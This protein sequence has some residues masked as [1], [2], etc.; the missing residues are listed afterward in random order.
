MDE[1]KDKQHEEV[2]D[3]DIEQFIERNINFLQHPLSKQRVKKKQIS[4]EI[5]FVT[6]VYRCVRTFATYGENHRLAHSHLS[7]FFHFFETYFATFDKFKLEHVR[8]EFLLFNRQVLKENDYCTYFIKMLVDNNILSIEIYK[9]CSFEELIFFI[10]ILKSRSG[11]LAEGKDADL[12]H[13]LKNIK[14]EEMPHICLDESEYLEMMT[15]FPDEEESIE[16]QKDDFGSMTFEGMSLSGGLDISGM[17]M[18]G[19]EGVVAEKE[20]S[21]VR[22]DEYLETEASSKTLKEIQQKQKHKIPK[23]QENFALTDKNVLPE[24]QKISQEKIRSHEQQQLPKALKFEKMLS[25]DAGRPGPVERLIAQS[26]NTMRYI[27]HFIGLQFIVIA[28][29]VDIVVDTVASYVNGIYQNWRWMRSI[30]KAAKNR[31]L[32]AKILM[33]THDVNVGRIYLSRF[34]CFAGHSMQIYKKQNLGKYASYV[35]A[36]FPLKIALEMREHFDGM[37][38]S[39]SL[40]T[41]KEIKQTIDK[42]VWDFIK[43]FLPDIWGMCTS[44]KDIF[45]IQFSMK[46]NRYQVEGMYVDFVHSYLSLIDILA[47]NHDSQ[48][49]NLP[50]LGVYEEVLF[51]R[52]HR[53]QLKTISQAIQSCRRSLQRLIQIMCKP[54]PFLYPKYWKRLDLIHEI[55]KSQQFEMNSFCELELEKWVTTKIH[56]SLTYR[57]A[58]VSEE[59]QQL[60]EQENI[61]FA[62]TYNYQKLLKDQFLL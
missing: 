26:E 51:Q 41:T 9:G 8:S 57:N 23:Q 27:Q 31:S 53:K 19:I 56:Q 25:E 47:K 12:L 43:S 50:Q 29:L 45:I 17:D 21:S 33:L 20:V 39:L 55:Q 48:N 14:I 16:P 62:T 6:H 37:Q 32:D 46:Y 22:K 52:F 24:K 60:R 35:T 34:F 5:E 10:K 1:Y 40:L 49:R 30:R 18:G 38:R 7:D 3:R 15:P 4:Q 61:A 54:H 36:T 11:F 2:D 59:E 13:K 28:N 58:Y 42:S 44:F